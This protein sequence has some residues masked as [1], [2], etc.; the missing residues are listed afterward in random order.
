MTRG[1]WL[2]R[3]V[4]D[5][6]LHIPQGGHKRV[7]IQFSS[8]PFPIFKIRLLGKEMGSWERTVKVLVFSAGSYLS[9]LSCSSHIT[10]SGLRSLYSLLSSCLINMDS[11]V[12]RW[13]DSCLR[14]A[15]FCHVYVLAS[16][17][18]RLEYQSFL[19]TICSCSYS[20]PEQS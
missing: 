1:S 8:R 5:I 20:L 15:C 4:V 3:E 13:R 10:H 18:L 19:L 14:E 17:L 2:T 7:Y 9:Y 12:W 11:R 6:P 16:H